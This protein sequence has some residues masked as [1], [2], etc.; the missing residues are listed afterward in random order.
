MAGSLLLEKRLL[1]ILYGHPWFMRTLDAVSDLDLPYGCIGGGSIRSI[2]FDYLDG[3]STSTAIR[4]VDVVYFDSSELLTYKDKEYE[5]KNILESHMPN[6]PWDVKNQATVHL[7]F[8]EKFG[9]E[10]SP[11]NCIEDSI[12]TWPETCT[13]ITV[14]KFDKD[15]YKVCA[16]CGLEDLFGMIIRRNPIRCRMETYNDRISSRQ[17]NQCWKSVKIIN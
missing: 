4:D 15:K 17:Y 16:P 2:V 10:V 6:I 13:A 5:Y 11:V 12:A 14:T 3:K 1:T 7:W 8:H 9:H